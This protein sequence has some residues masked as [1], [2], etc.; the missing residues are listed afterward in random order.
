SGKDLAGVALGVQAAFELVSAGVFG[1]AGVALFCCGVPLMNNPRRICPGRVWAE[2]GVEPSK[3]KVNC[4]AKS[5]M[6]IKLLF[7]SQ[8]I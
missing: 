1:S 2:T 7:I 6:S 5:L 8:L 4:M 3:I